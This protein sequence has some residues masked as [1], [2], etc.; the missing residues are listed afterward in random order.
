MQRP[1][2]AYLLVGLAVG[3]SVAACS[4]GSGKRPDAGSIVAGRPYGFKVP[5]G[6]VSGTPTP[7]VI[8]IH[9]YGASGAGQES[10]FQLGAVADEQTFLYATPDGTPDATGRRFWNADDACCDFFGTGVDDVGHLNAMIDDVSSRHRRPETDRPRPA[11][12]HHV[13]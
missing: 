9:G 12:L 1:D 7:L 3:I 2:R 6:Y 8:L 13:P 5:T 4:S 10:Y 11:Q